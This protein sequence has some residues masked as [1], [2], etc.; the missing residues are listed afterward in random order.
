MSK[1][2]IIDY[3]LKNNRCYRQYAKRT[4]IGVQMHTI[5]CAQGTGKAVADSMNNSSVSAL[6][7]YICDADIPGRVYKCGPE[8]MYTWADAGYGNRNLITIEVSESD[9]MKYQ[10]NSANYSVTNDAAFKADVSRGYETAVQLVADI[11]RRYKWDPMAKL[12]SGLFL[13]S[14]HDEGRRAGLSS[15]H[16]DPTHLWPKIGKSMDT[17][18]ADVVKAIGG[19]YVPVEV[20]VKWYRVRKSWTDEASQIGAFESLDN[21]KEACPYLYCVYD[22]DGKQV[23]KNATK[24]KNTQA[25]DFKGLSE[26]KAA[27]KILE[28]V[29]LNDNS[30]ILYSVT[31]A[32][33]I[34]E[35]GYVTTEL[36]RA[37]NNCFGMKCTLSGNTWD[38][39]W[40]GKSKVKIRTPEEYV[41]GQ[42]TYI[43]ADFRKYP[44]IEDSIKDHSCYLLGAMNGSKRRYA[45]LT[46]C[47][48]Y[49]DAI[50][51]IKKG[52]Y[53]TD[54][55]YVNKICNIIQRYSL[56]RYDKEI[57]QT[58]KKEEKK[59]TQDSIILTTQV[60]QYA[61]QTGAYKSEKY[62]N[63]HLKKLA[64]KGYKD[65][66]VQVRIMDDGL[67]HV[68]V[69][70]YKVYE[71]AEK[72]K[73]LMKEDGFDP[74]IIEI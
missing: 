7:T 73:A 3:P 42:I 34:L 63:L 53:A 44:C 33:M 9:F 57:G 36:S 68:I 10:P 52:G 12:P 20:E 30:G 26:G 22:S 39:V 2:N 51:L 66:K 29:H 32:Q 55:N 23:Y 18:R 38:S 27:E 47:K 74:I 71:N 14:S 50:T 4:P 43:Y 31:A 62:L 41:K 15:G 8:D 24:P 5:G 40:D 37:A 59:K 72:K 58:E 11:C 45:G 35:S 54:S 25:G 21:A 69:G 16:V 13:V 46:D 6:V 64:E 61:V 28:L 60:I 1:L 17:F 49:R 19:K 70:V 56:D 65:K 67:D 48:N